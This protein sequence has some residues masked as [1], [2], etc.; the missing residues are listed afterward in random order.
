MAVFGMA[1][2][3]QWREQHE[4][5][6]DHF[7]IAWFCSTG[8]SFNSSISTVG[9][10]AMN[11]TDNENQYLREELEV[12][13]L[14]INEMAQDSAKQ[15]ATIRNQAEAIAD[16]TKQVDLL[17]QQVQTIHDFTDPDFGV[18]A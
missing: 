17:Q 4:H 13:Q 12:A 3:Y 9:G 16:L 6:L 7:C 10:V 2:L 11:G 14:K 18:V 15:A 1:S 5:E 8:S